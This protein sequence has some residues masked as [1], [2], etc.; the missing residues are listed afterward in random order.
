VVKRDRASVLGDVGVLLDPSFRA[1]AALVAL[2]AMVTSSAI[3][4]LALFLT[5]DLG[6]TASDAT[7]LFIVLSIVGTA[8]ALS[9]GRL[10]DRTRSRTGLISFAFGCMATGYVLVAASRTPLAVI[11]LGGSFLGAYAVANS[12]LFALVRERSVGEGTADTG[13]R[14]SAFRALYSL[15][16]VIGPVLGGFAYTHLGARASFCVAAVAAA[17]AVGV[18]LAGDL[19]RPLLATAGPSQ[20]LVDDAGFPRVQVGRP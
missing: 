2:S 15:G 18:A 10:S 16:W 7:A 11:V 6:G 4:L 19:R 8:L 3:P 12:Q 13:L 1:I 14:S 20:P 5:Q 9:S 17:V